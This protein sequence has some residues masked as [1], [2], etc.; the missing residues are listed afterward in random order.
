[1]FTAGEGSTHID[2]RSV[3][4]LLLYASDL[5]DVLTGD[6]KESLQSGERDNDLLDALADTLAGQVDSRVRSM[7]AVDYRTRVDTLTRVRGRIDHLGTARHRLMESGR[8]MCRF[9]EQTLDLPRYRFMLVT[10]RRAAHQAVSTTVRRRCLT[11][12]QMLERAGVTP[13]DPLLTDLSREQYGH[14]DSVDRTLI[15]LSRLVREM[16]APEHAPGN[17]SLPA[18]V[19]N[20]AALRRLFE[21]AV[22]SF[23]R[24][25]VG[26]QGC[27]VAAESKA[28][29]A[30][31]S[32]EDIAFLPRLNT[33]VVIRTDS[34]QTIVECKFGPIFTTTYGKVILKPDYV[35][36][37]HAYASVYAAGSSETVRALL[38]GALVDGSRGRDLDVELAGFPLRVRQV[39]LSAPPSSVRSALLEAIADW[40]PSATPTPHEDLKRL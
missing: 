23:Y 29:P 19:R 31:G 40:H 10:L 35:R 5:L 37:I 6:D 17:V 2:V 16:C 30:T 8:V 38:L 33:D 4:F 26:G 39:D 22:R 3:W 14:F 20:E 12:A 18:V 25:H 15:R 9:S 32:P 21:A 13:A 7:L 36:Q 28:W 34:Y 24:I 1:M 11:T 27:T